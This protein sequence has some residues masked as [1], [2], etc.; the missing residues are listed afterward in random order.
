MANLRRQILGNLP[1]HRVRDRLAERCRWCGFLCRLSSADVQLTRYHPLTVEPARHLVM[2]DFAA[3]T[4]EQRAAAARVLR[5]AL[6][7][8]PSG[9]QGPGE[10]EAEVETLCHDPQWLG[11]AA[12]DQETLRGW[13]GA[14]RTYSHGWEMHP[15]VVD[16]GHQRRGIGSALLAHLEAHARAE[17]VLT[18]YLGSDDDYGGTNLFGR[19]L[20]P[21]VLGHAASIEPAG[22][23]HAFT[24]YRRHGFD[25]VGL[26]PDVNGPGRPDILLVKRLDGTPPPRRA[27]PS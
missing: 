7:H 1:R 8:L 12:L 2:R 4:D 19:E 9:F 11:F 13:I 5:A 10:A 26:L 14:L 20:F 23:G 16:P 22:P 18:V 24:F 6:A 21:D 27:P 3:L 25:V 15:L 17:G